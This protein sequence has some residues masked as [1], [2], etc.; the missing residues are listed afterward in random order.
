MNRDL[1]ENVNAQ[2]ITLTKEK[3]NILGKISKTLFSRPCVLQ[4]AIF[5]AT[6]NVILTHSLMLF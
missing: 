2:K 3:K 1:V 4:E 6:C 5:L